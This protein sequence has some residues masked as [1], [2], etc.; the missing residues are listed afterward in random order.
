[1]W[2]RHSSGFRSLRSLEFGVLGEALRAGLHVG[3][4]TPQFR[5]QSSEWAPTAQDCQGILRKDANL[6][7]PLNSD[8]MK[9]LASQVFSRV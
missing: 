7:N 9:N 5:V 1:M 4:A 3:V 8:A 6:T 2:L